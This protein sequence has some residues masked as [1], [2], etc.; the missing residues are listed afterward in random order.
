L[1]ARKGDYLLA[2]QLEENHETSL[3]IAEVITE[4]RHAA[5]SLEL[6]RTN[7]A[8]LHL[9]HS[10]QISKGT[11]WR[12]MDCF[13]EC[14]ETEV[15]LRAG[16]EAKSTTALIAMLSEAKVPRK[17][18]MLTWIDPWLPRQ[19]AV[20]L[21][22]GI[23]VETVHKLIRRFNVP[24]D[25][26]TNDAWPW[27]IKIRAFG[28][29]LIQIDD[30]FLVNKGKAQH[31]LLDLLRVII[32]LGAQQVSVDEIC[33]WLWPDADGD[34]AAGNLR[35]SLHRLRKLLKHDDAIIVYDNKVSLNERLCWLDTRAFE[36]L[37]SER[38]D[39]LAT[40]HLEK[41]VRLYRGHLFEKE[42]HAWVLPMRDRLRMRFQR[43]VLS[44]TKVYETNGNA[45][46]AETIYHHCLELDSSAEIVYRQLMLHLKARGRHAEALDVY[47]RCEVA[48]INSLATKPSPETRSVFESLRDN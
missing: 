24:A 45:D 10:R 19:F 11:I 1:A 31:K 39:E 9:T 34:V 40:Q 5:Y 37:T 20:A 21:E 38:D 32:A 17:A 29:L 28:E 4:A 16:D 13:C 3:K 33:E 35:T 30:E 25:S 36:H 22:K 23:E 27:P 2:L 15:Y 7:E 12:S 44:L 43:A 47:R 18:A 6:G 41:A 42:S 46:K 48:L 8:L 26:P 14:V